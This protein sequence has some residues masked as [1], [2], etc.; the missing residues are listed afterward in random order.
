[1]ETITDT[2]NPDITKAPE[3][4]TLI[5]YFKGYPAPLI[6]QRCLD[7]KGEIVL[8]LPSFQLSPDESD[9]DGIEEF[10]NAPDEWLEEVATRGHEFTEMFINIDPRPGRYTG[11][12]PPST[13]EFIGWKLIN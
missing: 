3:N 8:I 11:I 4:K 13:W 9:E 5:L 1:M 12:I 6:G 7:F 2:P 10:N